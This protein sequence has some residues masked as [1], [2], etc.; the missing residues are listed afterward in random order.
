MLY[1][2]GDYKTFLF[3]VAIKYIWIYLQHM[4]NIA[5]EIGRELSLDPAHIRQ[6]IQ[7]LMA[8]PSRECRAAP[9]ATANLQDVHDDR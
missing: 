9:D 6:R 4:I 3:D 1:L 8:W 2:C 7:P 5:K